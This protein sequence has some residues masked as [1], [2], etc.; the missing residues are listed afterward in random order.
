MPAIW[1]DVSDV[2]NWGRPPTGI[3]RTQIE[4]GKGLLD[5]AYRDVH[6]C[7]FDNGVFIQVKEDRFETQIKC[8][9][10]PAIVDNER[11]RTSFV[12][13]LRE[14]YSYLL[15]RGPVLLRN[16]LRC[17]VKAAKTSRIRGRVLLRTVNICGFHSGDVYVSLG[18]DWVV[19][20]KLGSV[21]QLR[22]G[23]TRIVLCCYDLIPLLYPHY[24][25]EQDAR[26]SR[27][28][29]DLSL[30]ADT[31]LCISEHAKHDL[32]QAVAEAGLHLPRAST[33]CLGSDPTILHGEVGDLRE[34][35][36]RDFIL[37][38]SSISSRKNQ[39]ALYKAYVLIRER[40]GKQPPICVCVGMK[41]A[42]ADE[43]LGDIMR[44]PRIK[45]DFR[46]FGHAS[47]HQLHWLYQNCLFT[48]FPSL[49]EGWGLP[50]TESLDN[51]KFVLA[52]DASSIP[53]AGGKFAEY[54]DPWDVDAWAD[55]IMYYADNT[56]A[57]REREQAIKS[58]YKRTTWKDSVSAVLTEI[59][60]LA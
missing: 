47:D 31:V 59:D 26:F 29:R 50:V 4:V 10:E 22:N 12:A 35:I 18:A 38:V 60:R 46:L 53:E 56:A 6:L 28:I 45:G 17:G 40:L 21:R 1:F 2:M 39:G 51:G 57:L 24:Q 19:E 20:G 3:V 27:Y 49:E 34:V 33:I 23:G 11:K 9:Q 7:L 36:E 37:Y 30:T 8:L 41:C 32:E 42:D 14:A 15:G 52:S 43:C 54:L 16:L 48:V 5:A 13:V 55:R 58:G 44:D 25:R